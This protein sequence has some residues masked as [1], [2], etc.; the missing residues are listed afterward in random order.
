MAVFL[1][2]LYVEILPSEVTFNYEKGQLAIT[3]Q[4]PFQVAEKLLQ[5]ATKYLIQSDNRNKYIC[6]NVLP[7]YIKVT[8]LKIVH[9]P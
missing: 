4:K 8:S 3:F 2:T 6:D 7:C 9:I 5:N 1:F